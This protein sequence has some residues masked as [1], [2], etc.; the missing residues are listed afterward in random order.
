MEKTI[1]IDKDKLV[2]IIYEAVMSEIGANLNQSYDVADKVIDK[3][4]NEGWQTNP[5]VIKYNYKRKEREENK[6]A[7][8][9]V[10]GSIV[11]V[12]DLKEFSIQY[13]EENGIRV[14]KVL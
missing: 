3:I 5:H 11:G 1:T 4:E 9:S 14:E 12:V 6:M 13:L 7:V 2:E 8:V 10:N